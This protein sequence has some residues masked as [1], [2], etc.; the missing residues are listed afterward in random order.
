MSKVKTGLIALAG[1]PNVGKSTVFNSIT[2]LNQHTGNWP[3][4][5]VGIFQGMVNYKDSTLK[6]VDLPGTYSL[7][8]N[9]QEEEI[10]RDFILNEN[11]DVV[12]CVIDATCLE[13]NLYLVFQ[14]MSGAQS[15]VVCLNLMDEAAKKGITIDVP[16]LQSLLGVPVIPTAARSEQGIDELLETVYEAV[17]RKEPNKQV[18]PM[19]PSDM[20]VEESYKKAESIASSVTSLNSPQGRS[21]TERLDDILTSKTFGIPIMLALLGLVFAVTLWLANYPSELLAKAFSVVEEGL[22]RI[23]LRTGLPSWFHGICVLGVFRT[24]SWVV[25]V[26][27][28]PMAIFFPLFTFLEDFGYLPRVAFNLDHLFTRSGGHGKQAL[29]M[30]M[31]FGCNAAGV[32]AARIIESPKERLIAILTNNFVPCNGRFPTLIAL[33]AIF[34]AGKGFLGAIVPTLSVTGMVLVG[35]GATLAVSKILSTTSLK[36]VPTSFVLELPPYR[37]PDIWGVIVRSWKDRTIWVLKRAVVVALPCGVVTWFLANAQLGGISLLTRMSTGLN[38]FARLLGLDGV[39]LTAF[40]L[41][42]PA[43]EIVLPIALMSYLSQGA[44]INPDSLSAIAVVLKDNGWNWITALS[45]SLFSLLH[46]PCGTTVYTIFKET[47][48]KKMTFLSVIIPTMV[49]VLVLLALNLFLRVMGVS[50]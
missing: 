38:P 26:M 23:I 43:N 2:G 20:S 13:R 37:K 42:F 50:A 24:V 11:P 32:V 30:S 5:T 41:G 48:S 12:V 45:A 7:R 34:F 25:S 21:L 4:K 47:G 22:T 8:A 9:S 1:N 19:F 17:S 28:P 40:I 3:G 31:G 18:T 36:G 29:T 10:A 27:L 14:V 44:M 15:C 33:S 46:F 49:A 6:F 39:I 35:V 16:K